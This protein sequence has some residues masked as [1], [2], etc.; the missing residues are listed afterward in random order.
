MQPTTLT[1]ATEIPRQV[2]LAG[3]SAIVI[4]A[5][6]ALAELHG[7]PIDPTTVARLALRAEVEVIGIAA[8]PQD[9]V[10]QAHRGVLDMDFAQPWDPARYR[11]LPDEAVAGLVVAWHPD[12][13]D[14]SGV[15][16][17]DLRARWDDGDPEVHE[18]MAALAAL[19]VRAAE[20]LA[21]GGG[22]DLADIIDAACVLRRRLWTF[23]RVDDSLL[24]IAD[25]AGAAATLAGSGGAIV[26]TRRST[27]DRSSARDRAAAAE[28]LCAAFEAAG[29]RALVPRPQQP[30]PVPV[31]SPTSIR[32]QP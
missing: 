7:A 21:A 17:G 25:E 6:E 2:G 31:G 32:A 14:P 5:I 4:G 28:E 29:A 19:A 9:R 1:F 13:G 15:V 3:S 24:A 18:V 16:H 26:A 30:P 20:D 10:V 22:D 23:S 27:C 11:R 12:P 8:G